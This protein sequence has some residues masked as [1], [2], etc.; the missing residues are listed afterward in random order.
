M[1]LSRL[2]FIAPLLAAAVTVSTAQAAGVPTYAFK[3]WTVST[4]CAEPHAGLAAR[5]QPGLKFQV[6]A[7]D[8]GY[9]FLA[10]DNSQ[11]HWAANWNG[12]RL[13]YRAGTRMASLPADF[14]CVAGAEASSPFLAMS[15]Y[16]VSAE[17]YYEQEHWYGLA[18]IHGQLE[19]VLIFPRASAGAVIVMQSAG[20]GAAIQLD[21]NGVIHAE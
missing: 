20:N 14:E 12:M 7:R 1:S 9:R 2:K 3:E 17:P 19:H 15:G 4:N 11:Q 10:R 13:A 18:R 5:V 16:V 21:D 6:V 8:G